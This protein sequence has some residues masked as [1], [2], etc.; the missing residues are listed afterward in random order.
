M[1]G[2]EKLTRFGQR[3]VARRAAIAAQT[4]G[5]TPVATD[6]DKLNIQAFIE[7]AKS[8]AES[9]ESENEAI[10][11]GNLEIINQRF[12]AKKHLVQIME[13]RQPIV[14]P[15]L[16]SAIEEDE[17]TRGVIEALRAAAQEN[18]ELL[19]RVARS[20]EAVSK[21]IMKIR[22]RHGLSGLYEKTGRKR[23]DVGPVL[24]NIDARM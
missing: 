19:E 22:D 8:L 13:D 18:A 17:E 9:L 12:E 20:A 6:E 7:L 21:E 5:V 3:L 1:S 23:G 14:E 10:R 2:L 11:G 16:R 4:E 24:E 15:F